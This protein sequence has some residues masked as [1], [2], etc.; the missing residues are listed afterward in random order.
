METSPGSAVVATLL[1]RRQVEVALACLGSLWQNSRAP[2]KL[3]IHDDGTLLPSDWERLVEAFPSCEAIPRSV[4]DEKVAALLAHHPELSR[5]RAAN[6]LL[7]KLLDVVIFGDDHLAYCD[8]DVYFLRPFSGLFEERPDGVVFMQDRQ[9]AYSVRSWH[10][11][12]Q[13][14]LRLPQKVNT[15]IILCSRELFDLDLLEWFVARE[16]FGSPAVWLEQTAWA[17]MAATRGRVHLLD[18]A[19]FAI[20]APGQRPSEELVA[21]HFVSSVR[22]E[23]PRFVAAL[24]GAEAKGGVRIRLRPARRCTVVGLAA[25]EARRRA[26]RIFE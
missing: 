26:R 22:S 16:Q 10:L 12:S 18:P 17:F 23:L 24:G 1:G 19:Q 11:L 15:G 3:R 5:A 25:Q 21:V 7:L 2:L 6:P 13:R 8:A 14:R 9:N 4:A 20:A